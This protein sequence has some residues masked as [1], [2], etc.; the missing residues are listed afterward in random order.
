M[1]T[2][3]LALL[4]GI[5]LFE[6]HEWYLAVYADAYEWA[7]V[8]NT[9]GMSLLGD[10]GLLGSKLH[11]ASGNYINKMSDYCKDCAYDVRLRTGPK[12]CSFNYLYRDFLVR[13]RQKLESNQGLKQVYRAVDTM[14]DAKKA[15]IKASAASFLDSLKSSYGG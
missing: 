1:V 10:G 14:S 15:D 6:A 5:D 8:P 2:G 4:A 13:N 7:E 11:A 9:L 3:N 12:A